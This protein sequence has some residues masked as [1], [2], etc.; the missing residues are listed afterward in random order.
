[1]WEKIFLGVLG[2][3][4]FLASGEGEEMDKWGEGSRVGGVRLTDLDAKF[5]RR[6]DDRS[7]EV[8]GA[9]AEADGV[10][11]LCPK[12]FGEKG[13]VGCHSVI[14]W[15]RGRVPDSCTPGPGRWTPSGTG[16]ADLTFVPGEPKVATSVQIGQHAHFMVERGEIRMC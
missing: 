6:V 9:M 15:F 13:V 14:C 4:I 12:C 3:S 5:L 2:V 7:Y 8:V 11:F 1:M 16:L 10:E